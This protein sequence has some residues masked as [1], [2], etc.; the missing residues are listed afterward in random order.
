MP[1]RERFLQADE[2]PK[3]FAALNAD[4]NADFQ[5]YVMLSIHT[6]AR[7]ANVLA[8]RWDELSLDG[9]RWTVSGQFT[10]NGDPLTI[11]LVAEALDV[12]RRRVK[13]A[14]QSPWVFPA[15]RQRSP[16]PSCKRWTRLLKTAGLKSALVHD[17]WKNAWK[18]VGVH[19]FIHNHD[20]DRFGSQ[21]H[22]GLID[23]SAPRF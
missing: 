9:A 8:M 5:D 2:C 1:S 23:L 10:K 3:F 15:L 11:R 18:L 20:D 14:G 16:R 21:E 6:G 4:A 13:E 12:L 22:C 7:R 19:R 17:L